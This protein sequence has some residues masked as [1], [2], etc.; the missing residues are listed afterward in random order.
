MK[1][2]S[3]PYC[4][5]NMNFAAQ[6]KLQLGQYKLLTGSL[7]NYFAGALPVE[8]YHCPDCGKLEFFMNSEEEFPQ[9]TC[10]KCNYSYDFDSPK[11]PHCKTKN[12]NI[13]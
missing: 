4:K 8:I 9:I 11:C 1:N 7:S 3:C 12:K 2:I 13:L 5:T 10:E 6:D